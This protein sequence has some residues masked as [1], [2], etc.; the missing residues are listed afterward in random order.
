MGSSSVDGASVQL[1]EVTGPGGV[2]MIIEGAGQD[3]KQLVPNI[4]CVHMT[5]CIF[6]RM[7][8]KIIRAS[9]CLLA[10]LQRKFNMLRGVQEG[11]ESL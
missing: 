6:G 11:F 7:H 4:R 2:A 3:R 10:G 1:F 8:L 5:I 9:T